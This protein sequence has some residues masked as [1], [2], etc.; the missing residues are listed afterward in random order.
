MRTA[1]ARAV[2]TVGAMTTIDPAAPAPAPV[3]SELR[4]TL[5][6]A[7]VLLGLSV[8]QV[9]ARAALAGPASVVALESGATDPTQL[10]AAAWAGALGFAYRATLTAPRTGDFV[11][12]YGPRA[13]EAASSPPPP[14]AALARPRSGRRRSA[15]HRR[16]RA[17]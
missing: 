3:P 11:G 13:D 6:A 17:A 16:R 14:A 9:A 4:E 2:G 15:R 10:V 12:A 7:R 5:A 8:A 1:A